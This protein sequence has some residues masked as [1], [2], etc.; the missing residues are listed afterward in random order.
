MLELLDALVGGGDL[1]LQA[2]HFLWI[3]ELLFGAG[4]LQLQLPQ[5]LVLDVELLFLF[6]VE[7]HGS[8]GMR[9]NCRPVIPRT[10]PVCNAMITTNDTDHT[11]T[12]GRKRDRKITDRKILQAIAPH[13][14]PVR[15]F[16]VK[17]FKN[18]RTRGTTKDRARPSAGTNQRATD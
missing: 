12:A 16:P 11:K 10:T 13:N 1:L 14:L 6:F 7:R 3:I 17:E 18:G 8:S 9:D 2:G 5:L 4:E 15:N